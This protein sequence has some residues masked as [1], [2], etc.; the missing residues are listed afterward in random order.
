MITK[1]IILAGGSGTRLYPTTLSIS[2]QLLPIYNKPMI[3]YPLTTLMLAGIRNILLIT[4]PHDQP[5][6]RNL[7]GDGDQWGL[8][9]SY[10][11]QPRPE[12]IAQAL[13]IG[14]SF[15]GSD[16]CAL[17]LGDNIFY[18]SGLSGLLSSASGNCDGATIF[19]YK[20]SDPERYGIVE[21]DPQ[22]RPLSLE[23]KPKI[24]K[25][26][27]AVTGLYFYDKNVVEIA[28][29]LRPSARGELE[30][31][32]VNREYF[33]RGA[34]RAERLGRG[35]AWLDTGT[36]SSLLV[37]SSFVEAVEQRQGLMIACPEEIAYRMGWISSGDLHAQA[38]KMGNSSYGAYLMA[39]ED[40]FPI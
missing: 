28:A 37:A 23:E 27:F 2:K 24:P 33:R 25:S 12:G 13:I 3:Y 22:G 17:A 36:H 9:L 40:S 4:A 34:L 15:I 16:G 19:A 38:R 11:V 26:P 7:L 1:G 39:I 35:F 20:V 31:T 10:E 21:L 6:F 5:M 30:I 18:G 32:D 14:E 29:G 8:N